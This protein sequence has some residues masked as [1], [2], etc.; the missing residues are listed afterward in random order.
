MSAKKAGK[1]EEQVRDRVSGSFCR[2]VPFTLQPTSR[3]KLDHLKQGGDLG[4]NV[5]SQAGWRCVLDE[6]TLP[7]YARMRA[8]A[9]ACGDVWTRCKGARWVRS[10]AKPEVD[11]R[12]G[13]FSAC[14]SCMPC[15]ALA[16]LTTRAK[17]DAIQQAS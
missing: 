7:P 10:K 12:I 11:L 4:I 9:V 3:T 14:V 1:K 15:C 13:G 5:A 16:Q 8:H 6:T 17:A 2:Q